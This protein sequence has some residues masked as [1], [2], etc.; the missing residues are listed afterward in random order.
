MGRE[1]HE[2]EEEHQPILTIEDQ[3]SDKQTIEF[4]RRYFEDGQQQVS[5]DEFCEAI[6]SEFFASLI[7]HALQD[8][9]LDEETFMLDFFQELRVKVSID[10]QSVSLNAL[11]L[12]T[13]TTEESGT[14]GLRKAVQELVSECISRMKLQRT[15]EINDTIVSELAEVKQMLDLKQKSLQQQ[16]KAIHKKQILL[17]G[18]KREFAKKMEQEYQALCLKQEQ[19]LSKE[20]AAMNK[21]LLQAER[22]IA[23]KLKLAQGKSTLQSSIRTEQPAKGAKDADQVKQLK[24]RITNVEKSY[25]FSKTKIK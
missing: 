23:N 18:Q 13:R 6:Q 1:A 16:E 10:E 24:A 8:N 3:L 9:Q 20:L 7:A 4:W 5:I 14:R 25:E 12:F 17:E 19:K 11:E 2:T 22:S 21:K 15:N